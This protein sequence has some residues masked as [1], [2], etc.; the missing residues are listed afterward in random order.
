MIGVHGADQISG[1]CDYGIAF[2]VVREA[3][4]PVFTLFTQ[5]GRKRSEDRESE[6]TEAEEFRRQQE[7]VSLHHA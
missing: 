7:R 3:K 4:C 2:D 6:L 5:P 1:E